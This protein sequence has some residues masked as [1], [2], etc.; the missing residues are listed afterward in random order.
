MTTTI[1]MAL[2]S[3]NEHLLLEK[4]EYFKGPFLSSLCLEPIWHP[5]CVRIVPSPMVINVGCG[6][7]QERLDVVCGVN[8]CCETR[9][10]PW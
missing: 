10:R 8:S 5:D 7:S 3:E 4:S 6:E 9:V 1:H 2:A